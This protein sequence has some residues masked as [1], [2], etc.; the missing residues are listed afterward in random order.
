VGAKSGIR[1]QAV[2]VQEEEL[3][4]AAVNKRE[5]RDNENLKGT[6][7]VVMKI[8]DGGRRA[9]EEDERWRKTSD[10]GRRATRMRMMSENDER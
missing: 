10:G 5:G 1:V 3:E 8:S 6:H 2:Q 9:M 4:E 7:E